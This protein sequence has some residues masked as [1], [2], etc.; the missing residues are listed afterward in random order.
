MKK[1]YVLIIL[2]FSFLLSCKTSSKF[3]RN[4]ISTDKEKKE[5]IFAF[6]AQ[7]FYECLKNN[8]VM[9]EK[10]A[11]PSLNFQVLGDYNV[12]SKTNAIG[13]NYSKIINDRATWLKGGDLEG[14]KAI[15]NGCLS[16]FESKELDSIANSEYR[17]MKSNSKKN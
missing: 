10:D 17:N 4:E 6:K 16:F 14:Y 9:I 1:K 8:N 5:W 12:L 2:C 7:V 11:S 13:K 15:T 3:N